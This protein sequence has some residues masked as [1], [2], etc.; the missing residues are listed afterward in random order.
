[1]FVR[2][3]TE[4][5][6]ARPAFFTLRSWIG[7]QE[8]RRGLENHQTPSLITESLTVHDHFSQPAHLLT[9]LKL[10]FISYMTNQLLTVLRIRV[11]HPHERTLGG[12]WESCRFQGGSLNVMNFQFRWSNWSQMSSKM[13]KGENTTKV[14]HKF[15]WRPATCSDYDFKG[16]RLWLGWDFEILH[17]VK[18]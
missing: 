7:E 2:T 10:V 17:T 12:S 15:W 5:S 14:F 6:D 9:Q 3:Q 13:M 18:E 8:V 16:S 4:N 11:L 1:M